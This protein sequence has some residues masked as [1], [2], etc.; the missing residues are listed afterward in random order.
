MKHLS[1]K[2]GDDDET[3]FYPQFVQKSNVQLILELNRFQM[4][5]YFTF[6]INLKFLD[7]IVFMM[8]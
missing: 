2:L 4:M 7:L 3:E 1:S 6:C 8:I 5:S